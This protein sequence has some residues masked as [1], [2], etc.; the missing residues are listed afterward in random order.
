MLEEGLKENSIKNYMDSKIFWRQLDI[1]SPAE[2]NEEIGLIGVGGI[3]SP[4][5]LVLAKMGIQ[6]LTLWDDDK[7]EPHN[8]PNQLFR[9]KDNNNS[10][11][12]ALTKIIDDYSPH[13]NLFVYPIPK[14]WD[15]MVKPLMISAIDSM[16][17]RIKIWKKIKDNEKCKLYI[18]ARMGGELMRVYAIDPL[19]LEHQEFYEKVLYPSKEAKELPCTAQAIFYNSF[20]VAGLIGLLVKKYFK[21]EEL[22]KE[23]IFDL[24]SLS[25]LKT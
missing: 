6:K 12:E 17:T 25:F 2:M 11:V 19:N 7:V 1:L 20:I 8:I 10:K 18:E 3:G 16:D 5:A 24:A 23:I 14:K 15:G 13:E 22:P 21:D 4:T 9:R